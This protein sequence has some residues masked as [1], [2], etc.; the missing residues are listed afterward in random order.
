M[1]GTSATARTRIKVPTVR[2]GRV[3][4]GPRGPITQNKLRGTAWATSRRSVLEEVFVTGW[5]E[6]VFVASGLKARPVRDGRAVLYYV[7]EEVFVDHSKTG[8]C[9]EI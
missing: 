9:D 1:P 3:R 8:R 6:R 2:K 4:T 7:P 5:G